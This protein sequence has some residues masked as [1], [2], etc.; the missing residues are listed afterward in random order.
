MHSSLNQVKEI[1]ESKL[2]EL[3]RKS[4]GHMGHRHCVINGVNTNSL[5]HIKCW[6]HTLS[7]CRDMERGRCPGFY[8]F[9]LSTVSLLSFIILYYFGF[10]FVTLLSSLILPWRLTCDY[11]FQG[12]DSLRIPLYFLLLPW[13]R[14]HQFTFLLLVLFWRLIHQFAGFNAFASPSTLAITW[15]HGIRQCSS[16]FM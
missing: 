11:T 6:N 13:H 8:Y 7:E 15:R 5:L 10:L 2:S 4:D 12:E 3:I 14:I 9:N 1:E 16:F